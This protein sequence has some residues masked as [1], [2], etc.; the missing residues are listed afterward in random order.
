MAG[1]ALVARYLCHANA[2]SPE[3]NSDD[4]RLPL[5]AHTVPPALEAWRNR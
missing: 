3:E 1:D 5:P 2:A 4:H